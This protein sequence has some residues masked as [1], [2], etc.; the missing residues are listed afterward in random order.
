M[1]GR[2][3]DAV[4]RI[5]LIAACT[6]EGVDG[7]DRVVCACFSVG[8]NRIAAAICDKGLKSTSDIGATTKAGTNCGFCLPELRRLLSESALAPAF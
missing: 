3:I 8:R 2:T 5:A 7:V 4:Q 1:L 6:A